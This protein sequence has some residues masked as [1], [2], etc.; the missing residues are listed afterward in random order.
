MDIFFEKFLFVYFMKKR[1]NFKYY[2]FNKYRRKKKLINDKI[3]LNG[4]SSCTIYFTTKISLFV[5]K[6]W[7]KKINFVI[8]FSIFKL[9]KNSL[10][11]DFS[12][13]NGSRL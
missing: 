5:I 10:N 13:R 4:I 3:K 7:Q 8:F 9:Q 12:I 6:N 11:Y 2:K 1:S